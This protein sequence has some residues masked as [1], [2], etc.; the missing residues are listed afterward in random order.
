[1]LA[2]G[3]EPPAEVVPAVE[4][5]AVALGDALAQPAVLA[6][7]DDLRPALAGDVGRAVGRS[8]VDD[9]QVGVGERRRASAS[10][11]GSEPSSFQAGM[12]TI[13]PGTAPTLR[14]R[15]QLPADAIESLHFGTSPLMSA[16]AFVS[17][18]SRLAAFGISP[19]TSSIAFA[20]AAAACALAPN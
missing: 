12:K 13:V 9:E 20:Q 2:V 18:S 10:T 15:G 11:P 14:P 5:L 19:T 17:P 3:V 6:E 8:V 16:A 1:M 4:R 7:R